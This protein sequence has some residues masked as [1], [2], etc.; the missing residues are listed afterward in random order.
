VPIQDWRIIHGPPG[1]ID[2]KKPNALYPLA[3]ICEQV[4]ERQ[5]ARRETLG[6]DEDHRRLKTFMVAADIPFKCEGGIDYLPKGWKSVLRRPAASPTEEPSQYSDWRISGKWGSV[7]VHGEDGY[8]LSVET[9]IEGSGSFMTEA[10]LWNDVKR[11]LDFCRA[12]REDSLERR[13]GIQQWRFWSY[14]SPNPWAQCQSHSTFARS[15]CLAGRYAALLTPARSLSHGEENSVRMG[16]K[17]VR[18]LTPL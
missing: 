5:H 9:R 10:P 8:H 12:G 15:R 1:C 13:R 17:K 3:S 4:M 18:C 6:F 16:A 14:R 7:F 2:V 11:K